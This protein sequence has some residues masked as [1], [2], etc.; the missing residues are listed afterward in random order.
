[1]GLKKIIYSNLMSV[2]VYMYI[3]MNYFS[4]ISL[5]SYS[6]PNK[7]DLKAQNSLP[8]LARVYSIHSC[9]KVLWQSFWM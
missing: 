5:F 6:T 1:M 9:Y 4:V 8:I 3:Y 2:C 7:E